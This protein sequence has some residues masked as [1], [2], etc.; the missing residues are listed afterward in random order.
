MVLDQIIGYPK[1]EAE[2]TWIDEEFDTPAEKQNDS[3]WQET[4]PEN[5]VS[6]SWKEDSLGEK[7]G[8]SSENVESKENLPV[9][10]E[11]AEVIAKEMT[12]DEW[13]RQQE[14]KR[15]VPKYN[16]RKP[17]EGED[18]NQWKKLYVL[19]KKV[20]EDDDE[21]EEEDEDV[22]E[23]EFARRGRQRQL[24]D[25]QINFNDSRR[26]RGR[27]RGARGIGPRSERGSNIGRDVHREDRR[28]AGTGSSTGG[29]SYRGSMKINK[30]GQQSAPRVD[31][32]NDFPSL[33]T[34]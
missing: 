8:D 4:P 26:G 5:N 16:L 20:E 9:S 30:S 18:G 29:R 19:K 25:I 28:D 23:D 15:A 3:C 6:N 22:D 24:V 13:K 31:D 27:G 21:E 12:L 17:G 34:A 33:V 2:S 11:R 14:A 7:T 32:W 10:E 1:K